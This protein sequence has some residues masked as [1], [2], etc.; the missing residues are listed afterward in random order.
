[1]GS[2]VEL[3][4]IV[5]VATPHLRAVYALTKLLSATL[6]REKGKLAVTPA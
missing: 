4:E 5:G 2:V 1:M 3:G 6:A